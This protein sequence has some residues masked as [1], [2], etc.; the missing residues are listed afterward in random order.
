M[1]EVLEEKLSWAFVFSGLSKLTYP[2]KKIVYLLK[3]SV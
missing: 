1:L 3:K 2:N